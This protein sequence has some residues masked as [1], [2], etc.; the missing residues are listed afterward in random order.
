MLQLYS[1]SIVIILL[2]KLL[3]IEE[4]GD[5][6]YGV[7]LSG[8][9]STCAEFGFSLMTLRDVP[10]KRYEQQP[11]VINVLFQKTIISKRLLRDYRI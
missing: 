6:A 4:F 5:F 11:Y 2:A 9:I 7:S 3:E 10:Q 1:G 8:I